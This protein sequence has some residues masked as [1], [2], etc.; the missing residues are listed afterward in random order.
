MCALYDL[1]IRRSKMLYD[2]SIRRPK[3]LNDPSH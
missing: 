2:L 1:G 3:S